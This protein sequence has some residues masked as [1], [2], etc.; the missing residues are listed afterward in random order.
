MS[1]IC[2]MHVRQV[3]R[4]SRRRSPFFCAA[5]TSPS[6]VFSS[7]QVATCADR[8][9]RQV[10]RRPASSSA[11]AS[12]SGRGGERID[13]RRDVVD[14]RTAAAPAG[15]HRSSPTP[16]LVHP[17]MPATNVGEILRATGTHRVDRVGTASISII[18]D[19]R[20]L[21]SRAVQH[22]GAGPNS[23]ECQCTNVLDPVKNSRAQE[24]GREKASWKAFSLRKC[25]AEHAAVRRSLA[26]KTAPLWL[27]YFTCVSI[28]HRK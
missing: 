14:V 23:V 20:P 12:R 6:S 26:Q 16:R 25:T 11:A 7:I 24:E 21:S 1:A 17:K 22:A 15:R 4:A 3:R 13:L 27:P 5:T 28:W 18:R 19:I 2:V 8:R 9:A 10:R